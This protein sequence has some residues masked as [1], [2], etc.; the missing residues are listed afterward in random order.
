[1]DRQSILTRHE[2]LRGIR[3]PEERLWKQIAELI[4]PEDQDFQGSSAD[5]TAMDEIFDSTPLYALDDF[6]GGLFGQLTNPANDWFGLGVPD[7]D[8]MLYQPVKRWFWQAKNMVRSTLGSSFSS[9][10]TE[11]PGWFSD[12]GAFGLGALYSEEN[13]ERQRITDRAIPLREIFI[14]TNDEGT[15]DTVH[16]EFTLRGR[17]LLQK[18]PGSAGVDEKKDYKIIHAVFEN[19]HFRPG[20]LGPEGKAFLSVYIS[21]DLATLERRGGYDEMPYFIP[22]WSRRSGKVYPRGPGHRARPDMRTLQEMERAHLTA[23]EFASDPMKLVSGESDL[24]EADFFP[25]ALLFG[26]MNEQ[27]KPM[28]QALNHAQAIN[29]SLQQSEAK[30]AA[31]REA[32]YFSIMQLI[33]RPQMTATEFTGF[34]EEKLRQ[35]APNLE[36][37]QQGGL[38]PMITRRFRMLQR[39][40][41]LPPP[42]PEI[43]NHLLTIDYLS[44]LAKV[45]KIAEGR[46]T[47]TLIGQMTQLAQFRPEVMDN[48]D[49][50]AA[51]SVLHSAGSAPP[52][53]LTDPQKVEQIRAARAQQQQ[54]QVDLEN[55]KT[56]VEIAATAGHAQQAA[57]LA[58]GRAA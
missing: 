39:A 23:A 43:E 17:Q 42:P 10:Y 55:T 1:M 8:L 25:G 44:P 57:T 4:R 56:S 41:Q 50:D 49:V 46:A 27:G 6:T 9:F 36:R 5:A 15:I 52:V 48:L 33:N 30:R 21:P 20:R 2:E 12:C 37:I 29:L 31:I 51:V 7:E 54:Q 58:K 53:L 13:I 19:P 28:V 38:T 35:L 32:F 18:F 34:Q 26:G 47:M 45:M 24:T 14:D 16:R 22:T 11:V 40:G 3:L